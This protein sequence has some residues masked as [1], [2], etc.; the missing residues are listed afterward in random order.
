MAVHLQDEQLTILNGKVG[1]LLHGVDTIVG[2]GTTVLLPAGLPHTFW[3][4]DPTKELELEVTPA[5]TAA[6]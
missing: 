1:Y 5:L 3:N 2:K 4:A 6:A